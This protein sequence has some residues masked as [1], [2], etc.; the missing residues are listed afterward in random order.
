MRNMELDRVLGERNR[1]QM[2]LD[3]LAKHERVDWPRV[4]A[5]QGAGRERNRNR[6]YVVAHDY[7]P[8]VGFENI[9]EGGDWDSFDW[10][11]RCVIVMK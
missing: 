10:V 6:P 3:C 1:L 7:S 9:E 11:A 8:G 4:P 5:E 2:F